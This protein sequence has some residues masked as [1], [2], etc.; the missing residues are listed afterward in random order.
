LIKFVP[1][2]PMSGILENEE[3]QNKKKR[4]FKKVIIEK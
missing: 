1:V 4:R 2:I 3:D